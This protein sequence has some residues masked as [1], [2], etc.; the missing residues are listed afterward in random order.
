MKKSKVITRIFIVLLA[1]QA[2][3]E[4]GLGSMLLFDFQTTLVSAFGIKY[5]SQLDILGI[6]LGLYLL[7][8]TALMN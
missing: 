5:S 6:A 1:I 7:L 4:L 8:L 3:I 2:I